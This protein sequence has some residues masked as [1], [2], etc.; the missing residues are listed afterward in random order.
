MKTLLHSLGYGYVVGIEV[1]KLTC[2]V[3]SKFS[4]HQ[5]IENITP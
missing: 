2:G 4:D 1:Y 3:S 5:S